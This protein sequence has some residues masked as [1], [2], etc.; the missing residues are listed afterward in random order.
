[1]VYHLLHLQ[2]EEGLTPL[3]LSAC[4]TQRRVEDLEE[5]LLHL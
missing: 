2:Q 4:Q 1:M 3:H 5:E